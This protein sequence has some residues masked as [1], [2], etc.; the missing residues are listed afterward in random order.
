M[1]EIRTVRHLDEKEQL[2]DLFRVSF[3]QDMSA[4]LWDWKYIKNPQ[5]SNTAEVIV[6]LDEGKIVGARP[7]LLSEMWIAN[8]KLVTAQHCDAAPCEIVGQY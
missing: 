8:E 4:E 6:A 3:N 7:F 2:L 1:I 5:T